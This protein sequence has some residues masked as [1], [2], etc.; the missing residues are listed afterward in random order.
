MT[1]AD[2]DASVKVMTTICVIKHPVPT[3][4]RFSLPE[5]SAR[6]RAYKLFSKQSNAWPNADVTL[7]Q[8]IKIK[9]RET[10]KFFFKTRAVP[11]LNA[12]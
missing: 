5:N 4:S 10:N 2:A 1:D 11:N 6:S 12:L 3:K 7:P 9:I 8:P